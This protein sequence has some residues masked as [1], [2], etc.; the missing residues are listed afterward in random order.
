MA[1]GVILVRPDGSVEEL[2]GHLFRPNGCAI[3][4]D[5]ST[6]VVAET[7][8]HRL[9]RFTI[10]PDGRLGEQSIVLRPSTGWLRMPKVDDKRAYSIG[11]RINTFFSGWPF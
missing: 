11:I 3:T 8:V 4:A 2:S 1:T 5:G 10:G 7:R 9:A 6:L